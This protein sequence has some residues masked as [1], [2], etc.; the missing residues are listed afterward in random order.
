MMKKKH[1]DHMT[2]FRINIMD[3]ALFDDNYGSHLG[4]LPLISVL[5]NIIAFHYPQNIV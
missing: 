4:F 5:D 3:L 2:G 1:I